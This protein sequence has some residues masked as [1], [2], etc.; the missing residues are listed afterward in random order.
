MI[1]NLLFLNLIN[2]AISTEI[3]L[4]CKNNPLSNISLN[5]LQ[6]N[7]FDAYIFL[8]FPPIGVII[9][10]FIL[11]QLFLKKSLRKTPGDYLI[12]FT[13]ILIYLQIDIFIYGVNYFKNPIINKGSLCQTL[14]YLSIFFGFLGLFYSISPIFHV[15]IRFRSVLK[16]NHVFQ[17]SFHSA[18]ISISFIS[19]III[20]SVGNVGK[21]YL[22]TCGAGICSKSSPIIK[23]IFDIIFFMI[24]IYASLFIKKISNENVGMASLQKTNIKINDSEDS[25]NSTPK[26]SKKKYFRYNFLYILLLGAYIILDFSINIGIITKIN[27]SDSID[28]NL[29]GFG[30][31]I[32]VAIYFLFSIIILLHPHIKKDLL[33]F[34]KKKTFLTSFDKK[35]EDL[36][37]SLFKNKVIPE[38][39]KKTGV[40]VFMIGE[41]KKKLEKSHEKKDIST[42]WLDLLNETMK[43]NLIY[44][45]IKG[46]VISHKNQK[47]KVIE[48]NRESVIIKIFNKIKGNSSDIFNEIQII[49]MDKADLKNITNKDENEENDLTIRD[50]V[51]TNNYKMKV[52]A[53]NAFHRIFQLDQS[54]I[55]IEHSLD[56]NY[57]RNN[58]DKVTGKSGGGKSGE[59]FLF[60]HDNSLIVK[61]IS[62]SELQNLGLNIADY[63]KH[64]ISNPHS[65]ITKIYGLYSIK[66]PELGSINYL[67]LI[68]LSK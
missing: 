28:K 27:K 2:Q 36:E 9:C 64:L 53:P 46:I 54:L 68:S 49:T 51:N 67:N 45:I 66:T 15:I 39:I 21:N 16:K 14:G 26:I 31:F 24:L 44:S 65:L 19:F 3:L 22:G 1:F 11:I 17:I 33:I 37:E 30:N 40:N 25:N 58:I 6:I 12:I 50:I 13:L 32:F 57:N 47:E 41:L 10:I 43:V 56:L 34:I 63:C 52:Y 48:R 23:I 62:N 29:G 59:F 5:L 8:I 38:S 35:K 18:S 7:S 61:T 42:D 20:I 60:T 4:D 55:N